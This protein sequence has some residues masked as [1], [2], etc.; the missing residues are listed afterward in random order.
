MRKSFIFTSLEVTSLEQF[1][2]FF[3]YRRYMLS[4]LKQTLFS[5]TQINLYLLGTSPAFQ[6]FVLLKQYLMGLASQG[7][8][9]CAPCVQ[10]HLTR[11]NELWY[12]NSGVSH[13][14]KVR[15]HLEKTV[16]ERERPKERKTWPKSILTSYF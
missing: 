6:I 4:F 2:C 7:E 12:N 1:R 5:S 14:Q 11:G 15:P 3:L 13:M 8:M 10:L 9:L 16:K